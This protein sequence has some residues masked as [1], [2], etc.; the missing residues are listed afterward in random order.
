MRRGAGR[1]AEGE[2]G[3][4]V[5]ECA[6]AALGSAQRGGYVCGGGFAEDEEFNEC[7]HE[8]N[9]GELAEEE[10]LGERETAY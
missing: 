3:P 6:R 2:E 7:A 9:D 4:F 1:S 5:C 10:T 8:N